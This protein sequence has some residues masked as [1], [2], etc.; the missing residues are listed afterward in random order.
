M[1]NPPFPATGAGSQP[2]EEDGS[3]LEYMPMPDG[4]MTFSQPNTPEPEEVENLVEAKAV[5]ESVLQALRTF[6][7]GDEARR[8]DLSRLDQNNLRF[9]DQVLGSGEV[10]IVAG[11]DAQIQ[12]SVMAGIWRVRRAGTD[13]RIAADV[14]EIGHVPSG[15][16]AAAFGAAP[17]FVALNDSVPPAEAQTSSALLSE[18]NDNLA[19][20][21]ADGGAY[22]INL[23]LLP[24]TEADLAYLASSLGGGSVVILSRGYGNCR[25]SSTGTR[26]VWWVQYYNSQDALILNTIEISKVPEVA[27]AAIE[28]IADSADRLDEILEVY[29]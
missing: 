1:S 26:N 15:I 17:E 10:S 27:C 20:P 14:V 24:H 8:I 23:S 18:I 6:R 11:S 13:G 28:D 22:T 21:P 4:M 9:V 2:A 25:I 5:L 16:W 29:R 12:E 3:V 7:R 19:R